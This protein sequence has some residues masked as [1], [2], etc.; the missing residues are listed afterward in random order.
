[1]RQAHSEC[2]GDY[3]RCS[4]GSEKLTAAARAGTSPA[5]HLPG[6]FQRN[7]TMRKSCSNGLDCSEIF[8][9]GGRKCYPARH[10]N[11]R[12]IAHRSQCHHHCGQAF[13]ASRNSQHAFSRWQTSYQAAKDCCGIITISEAV[14]HARRALCPPIAWVRA[15]RRE[16]HVAEIPELLCRCACQKAQLEVPGVIAERNGRAVTRTNSALGA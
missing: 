7:F 16:R 3:L 15:E 9:F 13:V 1:M 6:I 14:H 4:C 10:Q 12:Q 2:L 8:T 5:R 11:R